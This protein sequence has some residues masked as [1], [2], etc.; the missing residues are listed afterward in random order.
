MAVRA[1]D[2][3]AELIDAVCARVRERLPERAGRPVRVVRPPVLPL[4]SGRGSRRAR[5]ARP[6][7]R[8][9][10]P[11]EPAASARP[12]ETKVHV[13]NPDFEQHGW[14]SPHTVIEIVSDDMPFLVDSVTME[15]GRQ[16]YVIDLVI[17]PVI[18]VRR[19]ADG[20]LTEVLEP[21]AERRRRDRRVDHPRR[22]RARDRPRTPPRAARRHRARAR[23]RARARSRTGGDARA[24]RSARS[25]SSSGTRRRSTR[26]ARARCKAFLRLARRRPL[27]VPRLPRVRARST[28]TARPGCGRFPTRVW[29]SCGGRRRRRTRRCGRRRS[30]SRGRRTCWC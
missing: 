10:R 12:G 24:M 11:L 27:H 5:P 14:Q 18:R 3:E 30:R 22:G 4:G 1:A 17:H 15:L 28:G 9:G 20:A 25:T 2:V 26:R 16:G 29:G 7:R 19:D 23:R 21:G 8:R 6:V 13:Y